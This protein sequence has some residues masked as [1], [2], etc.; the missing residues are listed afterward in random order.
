MLGSFISP[1]SMYVIY[2]QSQYSPSQLFI[3]A[4]KVVPRSDADAVCTDDRSRR[5]SVA[6]TS[7]SCCPACCSDGNAD[8]STNNSTRRFVGRYVRISVTTA[9]WAAGL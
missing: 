1:L 5:P 2:S 4:A 6:T 3:L 7:Q 8:V 9:R